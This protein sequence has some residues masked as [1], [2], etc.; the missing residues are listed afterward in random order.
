MKKQRGNDS[1]T[2]SVDNEHISKNYG[3][4]CKQFSSSGKLA[5]RKTTQMRNSSSSEEVYDIHENA[6]SAL[7]HDECATFADH[8]KIKLEKFGHPDRTIIMHKV[9][10]IIFEAEMRKYGHHDN[11]DS[12]FESRVNNSKLLNSSPIR[13]ECAW[14]EP[15][16]RLPKVEFN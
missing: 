4:Q 2:D 15:G 10:N 13:V 8:V 12:Q 11:F 9:N 1:D 5:K 16:I 6:V 3:E 7:V 14:S